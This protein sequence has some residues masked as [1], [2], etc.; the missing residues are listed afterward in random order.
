M[1][2]THKSS[3]ITT[4]HSSS[5]WYAVTLKKCVVLQQ[6]ILLGDSKRNLMIE[7]LPEGI[8]FKEEDLINYD[9]REGQIKG[10]PCGWVVG[11]L[12][13]TTNEALERK[14]GGQNE[15]LHCE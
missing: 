2:K 5:N 8:T 11:K 15:N 4:A 13:S 1:K 9:N 10:C 12:E 3:A 6:E 14:E 7:Y